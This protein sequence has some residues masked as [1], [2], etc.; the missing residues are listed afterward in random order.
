MNTAHDLLL[1]LLPINIIG[2]LTLQLRL[3]IILALV[4]RTSI[5]YV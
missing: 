5:L 1:L 4:M 2:S 3:K